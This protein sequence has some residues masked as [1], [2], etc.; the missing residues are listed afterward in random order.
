MDG[1]EIPKPFAKIA[2][3]QLPRL[4]YSA[5]SADSAGMVAK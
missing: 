5:D 4:H 1:Y 2:L 3:A